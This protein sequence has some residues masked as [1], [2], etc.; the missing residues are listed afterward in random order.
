[1][2]V[3]KRVNLDFGYCNVL[4]GLRHGRPAVHYFRSGIRSLDGGAAARIQRAGVDAV[5]V[6]T[7]DVASALM[8]LQGG[9]HCC[10][11]SR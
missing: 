5:P 8:L 11:G 2:D 6:S 1:M 3:F 9:L 4:P 10:C 7:P